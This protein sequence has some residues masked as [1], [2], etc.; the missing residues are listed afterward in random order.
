MDIF[1][2]LQKNLTKIAAATGGGC[3]DAGTGA[4]RCLEVDVTMSGQVR[5]CDPALPATD[6]QGC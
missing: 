2:A 5:M 3:Q 6:P 1:A 4:M